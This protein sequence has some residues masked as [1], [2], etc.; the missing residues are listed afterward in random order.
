MGIT[1]ASTAPSRIRSMYEL[2]KSAIGGMWPMP[3]PSMVTPKPHTI[4]PMPL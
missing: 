3:K 4:A 1:V 2:T